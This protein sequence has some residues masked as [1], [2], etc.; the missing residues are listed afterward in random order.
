MNKARRKQ[1]EKIIARLEDLKSSL[2]SIREDFEGIQSDEQEAFDNIPENLQQD[3]ERYETAAAAV[4][5]LDSAEGGFDE[6]ADSIDSIIGYL[7]EATGE[8]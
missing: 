4:D 2:E 6:V 1:I 5:A 7:N 3:S 8:A